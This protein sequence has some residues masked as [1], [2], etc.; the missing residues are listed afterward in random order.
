MLGLILMLFFSILNEI[1]L[2]KNPNIED[3]VPEDKGLQNNM[4]KNFAGKILKNRKKELEIY[5]NLSIVEKYK[6]TNQ[7]NF[8]FL[9]TEKNN[10]DDTKL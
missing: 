10:R 6:K 4:I 1:I 8:E 2:Y 7:P 5:D 9:S 3:F